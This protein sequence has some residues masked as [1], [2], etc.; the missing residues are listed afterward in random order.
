[1]KNINRKNIEKISI[2]KK[3]REEGRITTEFEIIFNGLL[4]EEIIALKL[5]LASAGIFNNRLFGLPIIHS[6]TEMVRDATLKWTF[7]FFD[8]I[9]DGARFLGINE[10]EYSKLLKE[11]EIKKYFKELELKKNE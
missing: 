11:Y 7:A 8:T 3:L 10:G 6:L 1:M 4:L 2:V 5:E 9:K